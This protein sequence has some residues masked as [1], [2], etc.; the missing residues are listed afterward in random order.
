MNSKLNHINNWPERARQA[1]WSAA[2]L[3]KLCDVSVRTLERFFLKEMGENPK[4]WLLTQRNVKATGLLK[5]GLSVKETAGNLGYGHFN[6]FSR[7]YKVYTG[8][9][10]TDKVTLERTQS[11]N[12]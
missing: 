2:A 5:G 12:L 1:N 3:A 8:C 11:T 4:K 10:P 9:C 6:N 7:D